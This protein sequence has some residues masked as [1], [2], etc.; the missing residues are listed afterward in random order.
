MKKEKVTKSDYF[1][2]DQC[3]YM[4]PDCKTEQD[5]ADKNILL[6]VRGERRHFHGGYAVYGDS[7]KPCNPW[8]DTKSCLARWLLAER[9]RHEGMESVHGADD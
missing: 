7:N 1:V 3:G 9:H 4:I 2:C 8:D 6:V 5:I